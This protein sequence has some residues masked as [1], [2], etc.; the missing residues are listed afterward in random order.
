M[1][2]SNSNQHLRVLSRLNFSV[3]IN[4]F[5]LVRNLALIILHVFANVLNLVIWSMELISQIA[6][7]ADS[8]CLPLLWPWPSFPCPCHWLLFPLDHVLVSVHK[9]P[10]SPCILG[11]WFALGLLNVPSSPTRMWAPQPC[12]CAAS[13]SPTVSVYMLTPPVMG[14][15]AGRGRCSS[16]SPQVL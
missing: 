12:H 13:C 7:L 6:T 2:T 14:M 10:W 8:S 4:P 11:C 15:T 3:L 16:L 9:S 1:D 5:S